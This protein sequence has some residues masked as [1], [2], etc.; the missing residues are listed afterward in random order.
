MQSKSATSAWIFPAIVGGVVL[1]ICAIFPPV[2][3]ASLKQ[4]K[5]A[6]SSNA[7]NAT[8]VAGQFWENKLLPIARTAPDALVVLHDFRANPSAAIAKYGKTS[9]LGGPV[10]FLISGHG[11]ISEKN[12]NILTLQLDS[13]D[14]ND[15]LQI[16]IGPL[17][18]N[19]V[20][21]G[22]GLLNVS[23]FPNSIEF[24]HVAES[25]NSMVEQHIIKPISAAPVGAMIHFSGIVESPAD[26]SPADIWQLVP[27]IVEV[28]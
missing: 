23:E 4:A 20:R 26:S 7:F 9:G 22:T 17:F 6:A 13:L 3:F 27:V 12:K 14:K 28:K 24:N 2:H 18:G 25:L 19:A 15:A 8:R 5:L 21:D 16:D 11:K 10:Y 1:L